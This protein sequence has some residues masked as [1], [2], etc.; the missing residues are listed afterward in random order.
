MKYVINYSLFSTSEDITQVASPQ[1][2]SMYSVTN[3]IAEEELEDNLDD[4]FADAEKL[5]E[6]LEEEK[7]VDSQ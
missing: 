6:A 7:S 4:D 3:P 2:T 1:R 5:C